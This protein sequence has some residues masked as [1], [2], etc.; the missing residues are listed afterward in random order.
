MQSSLLI[1]CPE[2]GGGTA[3]HARYQARALAKAGL[4]VT[5]LCPADYM[6]ANDEPFKVRR[7]FPAESRKRGISCRSLRI[8]NHVWHLVVDQWRF[9]LE[10]FRCKCRHVLI[11]SYSEYL[12][13]L[14][15]WPH[16]ALSRFYCVTYLANLHDP[17]RDFRVGPLWWHKLS[18]S[19]AYAPLKVCVVH[20]HIDDRSIVPPHI[21]VIE[22]PVGVYDLSPPRQPA[23][24]TREQWGASLSSVVFFSF[25][26]IRDGKNVDLLIRALSAV[27]EA[28]LV[29]MGRVQSAATCKPV[30]FYERLATDEGVASRVTIIEQFVP[31]DMLGTYFHAADVLALTYSASFHSQSGVLNIVARAE[32]P[33]IASAGESPLKECVK[34][35]QLGVFVEPDNIDALRTGMRSMCDRVIARRNNDAATAGAAKPDW[36]GYREYASWDRNARTILRAVT[37]SESGAAPKS[38]GPQASMTS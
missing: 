19:L 33:I 37:K 25:G 5:L 13:P 1:Y 17:I 26:F 35:F 27:P 36:A 29:V 10:I 22:A 16:W 8:L 30:S 18:V 24:S 7:I 38:F 4:D 11:A 32:K 14:W 6:A 34:R 21:E 15:V 9:G 28:F 2:S 31:D 20:K 3:E 12:S 23:S